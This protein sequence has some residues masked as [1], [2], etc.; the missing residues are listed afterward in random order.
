MYDFCV[1]N[2]IVRFATLPFKK[3]N[4]RVRSLKMLTFWKAT[5]H[6]FPLCGWFR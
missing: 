6:S 5:H 1:K 3:S 2:P 4:H